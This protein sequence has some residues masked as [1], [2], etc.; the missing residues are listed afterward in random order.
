MIEQ[1]DTTNPQSEIH[2][3]QSNHSITPR[4]TVSRTF[5]TLKKILFS[6]VMVPKMY[7]VRQAHIIG[8]GRN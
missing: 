1:R 6:S 8:T 3:P 2:D 4:P 7:T 5:D